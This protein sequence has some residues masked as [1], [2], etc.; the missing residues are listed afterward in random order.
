MARLSG[1][2]LG[3]VQFNYDR[4]NLFFEVRRTGRYKEGRTDRQT[5]AFWFVLFRFALFRFVCFVSFASF[6]LVYFVSFLRR[7]LYD[8]R[9]PEKKA[10][11]HGWSIV[12]SYIGSV[13][14]WF[15]YI[16]VTGV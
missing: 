11:M 5:E 14:I 4:A 15:K 1:L 6:C 10:R 7:L 3:R 2:G 13:Y 16:H 8:M 12:H 9:L